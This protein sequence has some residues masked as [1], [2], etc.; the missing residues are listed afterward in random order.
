MSQSSLLALAFAP[1][2]SH[3]APNRQAIVG[4][5]LQGSPIVTYSYVV[6][7][8]LQ[9]WLSAFSNEDSGDGQP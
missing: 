7:A 1:S 9:N 4:F 3:S 6:E 8:Y 5:V 2:R